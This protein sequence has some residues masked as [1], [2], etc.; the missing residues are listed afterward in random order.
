MFFSLIHWI[1]HVGS[2]SHF[3]ILSI[4]CIIGRI[5]FEV[6]WYNIIQFSHLIAT[7]DSL[8]PP[9]PRKFSYAYGDLVMSRKCFIT[10]FGKIKFKFIDLK[11]LELWCLILKLTQIISTSFYFFLLISC[12]N[13]HGQGKNSCPF[14]IFFLLNLFFFSIWSFHTV[15][16]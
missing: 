10:Q 12:T 11:E 6:A 2:I 16:I 15:F 1:G 3:L 14:C 5:G 4:P 7:S 9:P 8:S 13:L